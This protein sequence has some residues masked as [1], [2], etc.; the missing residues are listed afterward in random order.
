MHRL[1]TIA[2]LCA[3]LVLLSTGSFVQAQGAGPKTQGTASPSQV[4]VDLL[5]GLA[6]IFSRGMDT[7]T[8]KLNRQGYSARV[9]STNGWQSVAHRI[10]DQ[11]SR[12]HKDIIVIIGH[13]LGANATFD[14]ANQLDR[15][16]I[17]IELIVTFD[18]T[19][20]Q[21]VPKNV[22]HLVNFYQENGFGKPVSAGPNFKGELSNVDLTADTGLSHTTIEKSP[23]LHLMVMNKIEEV[24]KKDL[25]NKVKA[26]K[27]KTK[28]QKSGA[29]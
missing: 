3:S 18:A 11:Y 4:Q 15:Q 19:R 14:V 9:Y 29:S 21:P 2:V 23:R 25:A 17:P 16:N 7:L 8:E 5:R 28:R 6:D 1:R 27:P 12:G 22:L 10:A 13:S 26:A 24:V 20:P